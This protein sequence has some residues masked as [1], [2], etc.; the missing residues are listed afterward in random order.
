MAK[1]GWVAV[2][3]ATGVAVGEFYDHAMKVYLNTEKYRAVDIL[4]YL[5]QVARRAKATGCD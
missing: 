5:Q 2:D 4:E 3:R 1:Y